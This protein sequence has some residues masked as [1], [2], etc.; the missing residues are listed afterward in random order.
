MTETT[1]R[2]AAELLSAQS[3][4]EGLFDE[5]VSRGLIRPGAWES[6]ISNEVFE[7]AR[8]MYGVE[9]YWHKRIVRSGPNTLLPYA[10]NQPDRAL[11]DDDIAFLDFGPIF[12]QWEA[13][14]GR[15]FVLGQDVSKQKLRQ[16]VGKAF[17]QGKE[18]FRVT[19]DIT[20]SQ[21]FHYV[22]QIGEESG[23][24]FGGPMAGHLIGQFPH[25]RIPEDKVS[26]YIHPDNH[27]PIRQTGNDGLIRHWI[28]E[29]HFVNRAKQ[30]GG[31]FEE[32]LTV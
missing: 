29:I 14:F 20:A 16:D 10:E 24:E 8:Q 17:A 28:L 27:T 9:K 1:D 31:F 6:P 32:L 18:F 19:P 15:T 21:L 4:A 30:I 2:K 22:V 12:E 11:T 25:E 7:L 13:D 26:L 3:K 5:I 23:W